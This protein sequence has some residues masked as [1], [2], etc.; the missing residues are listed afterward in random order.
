[1]GKLMERRYR[2]K[3]YLTELNKLKAMSD[4]DYRDTWA[5]NATMETAYESRLSVINLLEVCILSEVNSMFKGE[6]A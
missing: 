1:M 6:A 5:R 2:I 3:V 4:E